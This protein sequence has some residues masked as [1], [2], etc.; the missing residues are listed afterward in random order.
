LS[1]ASIRKKEKNFVESGG[2]QEFSSFCL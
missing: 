2:P 1:T